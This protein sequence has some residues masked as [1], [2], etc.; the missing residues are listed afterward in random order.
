M[1]KYF[2]IGQ[3]EIENKLKTFAK[4]KTTD[5][6]WSHYYKDE[7]AN[8]EWKLM[9]YHSEYHGGGF[10]ILKRLPEVTFEKLID[11][12]MTSRNTS[13]IIGASQEL[14]NREKY[15]K[16]YFRDELLSRL[17]VIDLNHLSDF[18]KE[19]IKMV[20][21]ESGLLDQSNRREIVGKSLSEIREDANYYRVIAESAN[22][23]LRNIKQ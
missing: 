22:R 13:D 1:G 14:L 3:E 17:L 7:T 5:D 2:I 12:A 15:Q 6:G 9:R 4:I 8:E 23:I 16:E 10:P 21:R 18:E 11:I 19:R 20:I